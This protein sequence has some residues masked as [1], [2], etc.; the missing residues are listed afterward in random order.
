MGE[1][2]ANGWWL[3]ERGDGAAVGWS[4]RVVAHW[5]GVRRGGLEWKGPRTS[6]VRDVV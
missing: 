6:V 4:I 1:A 2:V 3:V 5:R